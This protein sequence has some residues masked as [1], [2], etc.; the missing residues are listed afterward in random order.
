MQVT[1]E[2]NMATDK[3]KEAKKQQSKKAKKRNRDGRK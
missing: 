1:K 3:H 2:I